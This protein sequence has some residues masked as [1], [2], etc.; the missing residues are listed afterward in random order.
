MYPTF[1]YDN[2]DSSMESST[3]H[4]SS[5]GSGGGGGGGSS[6]ND[7]NTLINRD[8]SNQHPI[9][10]VSNLRGELDIRPDTALSVEDINLIL[11]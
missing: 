11:T 8:M 10:S 5:G 6:T 9:T 1:I 4:T 7:H 3:I 2:E